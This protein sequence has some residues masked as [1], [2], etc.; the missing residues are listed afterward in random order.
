MRRMLGSAVVA[1]VMMLC[2]T[3]VADAA[4]RKGSYRGQTEQSAIVSFRVPHVRAITGFF[5][6]GVVM[7]CS[8]GENRQLAGFR[9]SRSI[10]IRNGKFE[11]GAE[12][13]GVE[14]AAVGRFRRRGRVTGALQ[15]QARVNENEQIDPN[16][17]ITCD[18]EIVEW[19]VRRR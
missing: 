18:S 12:G 16:G 9:A 8:D 17:A 1:M 3:A 4:V 13:D 11:F 10:P 14:F 6:E 7:E 15:V 2:V 19:A 5:W